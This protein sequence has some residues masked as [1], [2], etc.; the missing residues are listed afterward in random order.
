LGK[1]G[2]EVP[3]VQLTVVLSWRGGDSGTNGTWMEWFAQ[4]KTTVSTFS[5]AIG[6]L[7]KEEL[8]GGPN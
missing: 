7:R 4:G 8:G 1:E 5:D 6:A 3:K 2:R